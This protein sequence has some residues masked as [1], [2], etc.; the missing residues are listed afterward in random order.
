M[1][2]DAA[3]A[4]VAA[5]IER[6]QAQYGRQAFACLSGASL[7]IEKAYLMGKFARLCLKTPYIDY[8]GRLCMVSAGAAN[9]S[10]R[11]R[12]RR[13]SVER[14]SQ[15]RG[16]LD[17][18]GQ[19]RRVRAHHHGLRLEA[20]E[21]GA[22]IIVVDPRLTPIARTCDLFLPI[23]PGRDVAL[24]NG[25][26]HL[27]IE[28]DWLDHAFIRDYTHGFDE[29]AASVQAWTPRRTA[30]VTGIAERAIRQ[31]AAWWGQAP[32]SFLMHARGIEHHS[33][34]VQNCLGA[35][36]IVL[37]SG[38]LGRKAAATRRLPDK[39]MARAG[40]STGR[41]AISS[42]AGA[43]SPTLN[44]ARMWHRSGGAS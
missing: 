3:I 42:P 17:Q 20:R 44:T 31:A 22:K 38:R 32:T 37:A 39:P 33:H 16:C 41:S 18:W 7:T 35:I 23:K 30:E 26:L 15:G 10:V 13:Q 28:H 40:V 1:A 4:R 36:N 8:N 29:V 5:A 34:G 2:Y 21:H 12:P 9:E 24:F 6:I 25:I 27:M 19:R 11:H 43:T 14:H